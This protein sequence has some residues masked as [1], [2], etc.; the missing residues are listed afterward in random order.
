MLTIGAPQVS[1]GD[2]TFHR[3]LKRLA[4]SPHQVL[5][6]QWNGTPLLPSSGAEAAWASAAAPAS[7]PY[8]QAPRRFEL[9][10]LSTLL[11][12]LAP[13]TSAMDWGSVLA[14]TCRDACMQGVAVPAPHGKNVVIY[15]QELAV[16]LPSA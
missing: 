1:H 13:S 9:Q 5:R 16:V 7:C 15:C 4:R 3:F 11:S 12:V 14:F 2:M 8:C 6:Y 10:L